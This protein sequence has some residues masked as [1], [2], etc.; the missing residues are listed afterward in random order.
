MR[1][2]HLYPLRRRNAKG[3]FSLTGEGLGLKR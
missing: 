3:F 1:T 2:L